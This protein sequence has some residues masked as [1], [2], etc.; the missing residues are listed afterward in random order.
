VAK[1]FWDSLFFD[2][3]KFTF[4]VYI[5]EIKN[6]DSQILI[7][8]FSLTIVLGIILYFVQLERLRFKTLKSSKELEILKSEVKKLLSDNK[9]EIDYDNKK[10]L[11]ATH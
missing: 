3:C 6:E 9:W 10:F 2:F 7:Y 8:S 5:N 1:L 11:Q 4:L